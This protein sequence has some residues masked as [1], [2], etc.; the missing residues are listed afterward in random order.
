MR[1]IAL[2]IA[3]VLGACG[4]GGDT[5]WRKAPRVDVNGAASEVSFGIKIPKG[6]TKEDNHTTPAWVSADR[7]LRIELAVVELPA[8]VDAA[9]E[10]IRDTS[11]DVFTRAETVPG[12]YIVTRH[13][14]TKD[15][16]ATAVWREGKL[17]VLVCQ[18]IVYG[19]G[20]PIADLD[21]ATAITEE[22]CLSMEPAVK[23]Y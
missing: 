7:S 21:A 17:G 1:W 8:S 9:K 18:A 6:L 22:I 2:S 3:F 10:F 13:S 15:F 14:E 11:S 20:K 12:G 4:G 19:N 16:L 23:Y 5:D